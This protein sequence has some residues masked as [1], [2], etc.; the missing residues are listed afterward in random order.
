MKSLRGQEHKEKSPSEAATKEGERKNNNIFIVGEK[1][2]NV[3]E[4]VQE[5]M[6][7][8]S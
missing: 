2:G 5:S 8:N 3:N 1:G 6:D 4:Q 7:F